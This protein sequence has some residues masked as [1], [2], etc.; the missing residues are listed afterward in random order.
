MMQTLKTPSPHNQ[1]KTS[2]V[3]GCGFGCLYMILSWIFAGVFVGLLIPLIFRDPKWNLQAIGAMVS[4]VSILVISIP[5][6]IFGFMRH[7]R[8][9]RLPNSQI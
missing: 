5:L 9:A 8:K 6:G 3:R 4:Q 1:S 7:R 2:V